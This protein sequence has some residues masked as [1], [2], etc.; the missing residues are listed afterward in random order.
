M[1]NMNVNVNMTKEAD[2]KVFLL[3]RR[4]DGDASPERGSKRNES[5]SKSSRE[6][7][8]G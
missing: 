6:E 4:R 2:L 5:D 3:P 8:R 7:E 1:S